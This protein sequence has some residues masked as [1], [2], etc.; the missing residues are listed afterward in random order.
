MKTKFIIT[1]LIFAFIISGGK[2]HAQQINKTKVLVLGTTHLSSL[3]GVKETHLKRVLDSLAIYKF[4]AIALEQMP[5]ELL[6]DIKSRDNVAWQELYS[7]FANDITLG[8]KYQRILKLNYEDAKKKEDS[9]LNKQNLNEADRIQLMNTAL[10]TYDLWTASLN[11][12]YIKDKSKID[13]STVNLLNKYNQSSNELNL[14]GVNLAKRLHINK[15]NYIDNLQDETILS[16]DF[17]S[18][19]SEYAASQNKINELVSKASIFSEVNQLEAENVKKMDLYPLYKLLN[20]ERYMKEDYTGQWELWL[21]TNFNSK[22]DRSRFS[23][24]EMRNLQITANIMRLVAKYPEKTILV[25]IGASHKS[26]IEKYLQ[27]MPDIELL[28]F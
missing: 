24:W 19:F 7:N 8:E 14:I 10:C 17:P 28:K 5:P 27:Q 12:Q 1:T 6:F 3:S 25:V 16:V 15:L 4:D 2:L 13:T 23:L 9:L 22:T 26:F 11:F 18:F 21:K 20:S